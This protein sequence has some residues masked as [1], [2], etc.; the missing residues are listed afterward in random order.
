MNYKKIKVPIL[1]T[2]QHKI[3]VDLSPHYSSRRGQEILLVL[4]HWTGGTFQSCLNWFKDERSNVSAHYVISKEGDIIQMVEDQNKA[5][6]AGKSSL[7]GYPK[8]INACSIGIELEGPPSALNNT[9]W[10]EAQ[11]QSAIWLCKMLHNKYPKVRI[12]DHATVAPKRKVDVTKGTG[13]N[14][15]PW[16]WF[17]KQSGLL[18]ANKKQIERTV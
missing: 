11:L 9:T 10:P 2:T 14:K 5:W 3:N 15:F 16:K 18:Q 7:M 17:V 13:P 8:S 1:D 6:H 4:M 12:T